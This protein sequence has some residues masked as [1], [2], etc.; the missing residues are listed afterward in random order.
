MA[1]AQIQPRAL[2]LLHARGAFLAVAARPLWFLA[3][4]VMLAFAVAP[5]LVFLARADT[6]AMV[7]RELQRSGKL[8]A[9]AAEQRAQIIEAGEKTMRLALPVGAAAK[10]SLWM[11]LVTLACLFLLKGARPQLRMAPVAGAV[12]VAM[13]PLAVHD[14]LQAAVFLLKDPMQVDAHN[15]VLSNPAAWLGYDVTRTAS[16]ALLRGLDFFGLWSCAL[17]GVGV[18][19]VAGVRSSLPYLVAFCGHAAVTVLAGLSAS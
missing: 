18:N 8:A 9:A 7:A 6:G 14:M 19:T 15:A 3:V 13:A 5:S 11:T 10:R 1:P 17:V 4:V 12:A 16:G 2:V